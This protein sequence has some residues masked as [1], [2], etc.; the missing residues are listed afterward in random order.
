MLGAFTLL[1]QFDKTLANIYRYYY[2]Q[3]LFLTAKMCASTGRHD[4]TT[5][6]R[7]AVYA[8][9]F[10]VIVTFNVLAACVKS[11]RVSGS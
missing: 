10:S 8:S 1:L 3:V 7:K 4:E 2:T 5:E 11:A 6:E 9:Q